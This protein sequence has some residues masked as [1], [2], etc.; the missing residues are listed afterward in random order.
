VG[1]IHNEFDEVWFG[2]GWT[3]AGGTVSFGTQINEAVSSDGSTV[4]GQRFNFENAFPGWWPREAAVLLE[5]SSRP[6]GLGFLQPLDPD[7]T[8]DRRESSALGVSDEGLVVGWSG[9]AFLWDELNGMRALQ[10]VL[11]EEHGLDLTGWRLS[12]ASDITPDG[13]TIVGDGL[14]PDGKREAWI[15]FVPEPGTTGLLAL[16]FATLA[17]QRRPLT[18]RRWSPRARAASSPAGA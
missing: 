14:N 13:R 3:A 17:A 6:L 1:Y 5:G 16:G 7:T 10:D 8:D 15:A 11:E 4:V 2:F 9:R 18:P 12:S